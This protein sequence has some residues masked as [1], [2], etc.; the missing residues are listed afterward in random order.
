MELHRITSDGIT[1][2]VLVDDAM[3]LVHPVN[4]YLEYLRLQGRAECTIKSYGYDLKA[5]FVFLQRKGL[6]YGAANASMIQEYVE[7]LRSSHEDMIEIYVKSARTG[8]TINRMI[9]TLYGFCCYLASVE[10]VENPVSQSFSVN[11]PVVFKD[12]LYH[13]RKSNRTRRSVFKVKESS[14]QVHLLKADEIRRMYEVLPTERDKL[15]LRFLLQSGARIS[16]ALSLRIEDIPVPDP[17]EPVTILK[18]IKSKGKHRDIYIPTELAIELDKYILEN[19]S[20]IEADHD[21]V[22]TTQ[23]P[24]YNNKQL[25]YRG[26]YE[27][28]KRA[29]DKAGI[30]FKFHDT[31]HTYVSKLVESGMDISVV[32]IL[33]GH[34]HVS[35]T[36]RY[37]T[38]SSEFIARSLR[39]YWDSVL[40]EGGCENDK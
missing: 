11:P 19:R 30:E 34:V 14:Y 4:R 20:L 9:G 40:P 2:Y 37:V 33:A 6:T 35:T 26:I 15:I 13:T 8:S 36:Q 21:Y 32:R 23:H 27:V 38:L 7:Y 1:K 3:H 5:F 10:G 17:T 12:I 25:T 31:R 22:F 28:F 29:A 18:G 16:E 39:S 24:H